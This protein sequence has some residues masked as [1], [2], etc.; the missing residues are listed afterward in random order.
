MGWKRKMQTASTRYF[1]EV[2]IKNPSQNVLHVNS[3]VNTMHRDL[4][5]D[6]VRSVD[7][8]GSHENGNSKFNE[9]CSRS[10]CTHSNKN[11]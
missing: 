2:H 6:V 4:T 11:K 8:I 9:Q 10:G 5:L 3:T 1:I 7:L